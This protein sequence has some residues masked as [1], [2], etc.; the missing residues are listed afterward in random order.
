M[1]FDYLTV[2][3]ASFDAA[4]LFNMPRNMTTPSLLKEYPCR[5]KIRVAQILPA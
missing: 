3:N 5:Y 2:A 4:K 1:T